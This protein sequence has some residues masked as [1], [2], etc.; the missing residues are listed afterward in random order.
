M[1][2]KHHMSVQLNFSIMRYDF[3]HLRDNLLQ[4][5]KLASYKSDAI[6]I[7]HILLLFVGENNIAILL[8]AIV[9][10]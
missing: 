3:E 9:N 2:V 6:H 4:I 10:K 7:V 1:F 8:E 5:E